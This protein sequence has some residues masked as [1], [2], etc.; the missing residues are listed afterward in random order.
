MKE[1][2][3]Q[4][5]V[6]NKIFFPCDQCDFHKMEILF[7]EG[8]ELNC[9]CQNCGNYQLLNCMMAFDKEELEIQE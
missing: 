3:Q 2:K 5:K 1:E 8:N 9:K 6:I 7:L 4:P